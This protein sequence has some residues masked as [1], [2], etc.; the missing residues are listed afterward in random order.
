[1][2]RLYIIGGTMGSGKTT[3]SEIIKNK[4]DNSV[5]LDGDWCWDSHPFTVTEETKRMVLDNI[6]FLLNQFIR[7]S[8]YRNIIFCWVLHRQSIT[9]TILAGVDTSDCTVITV[10]LIC[11]EEE[12]RARLMKDVSEGKRSPDVIE[13]SIARLPCYSEPDTV[14]IDTNGKSPEEI[15]DEIISLLN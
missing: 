12:L 8:A 14:K 3:V 7:C 11:G 1:M 6:C 2:K 9:D 10:S 5:F 15:A 4:L 13:R